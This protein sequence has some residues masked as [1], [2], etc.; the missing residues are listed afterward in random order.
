[1]M[2]TTSCKTRSLISK[3]RQQAPIVHCFTNMVTVNQVANALL[4]IGAK[5][6]MSVDAEEFSHIAQ[7]SQAFYLNIG[8]LKREEV[9]TMLAGLEAHHALGHPIVLDPVGAG[10]SSLRTEVA[11]DLLAS[12]KIT[13]LRGN[14]SEIQFLLG[15][16]GT[17]AGVDVSPAE[18]YDHSWERVVALAGEAAQKWQIL[19][20]ISG[21]VD[22]I[23][24]GQNA[25]TIANGHEM[26]K[27]I[28][29]TGCQLTGVIGA[30][31][32]VQRD[33][34]SLVTAVS[35]YDVAGEIGHSQLGR[36]E[37]P[38]SLQVRLLDALYH[39]TDALLLEH[40]HCELWER[41]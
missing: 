34:D 29:G 4:A 40:S 2:N 31:L 36:Y 5:P 6:I 1:M 17:S 16:G 26:M 18:D 23:H 20:A 25:Y 14:A 11:L 12:G 33:I 37:G 7:I 13:A 8:T 30:F 10:A 35:A 28:T 39:M 24:D 22:I 19:V 38:A 9:A 32:A 27:Y 41:M 3:L 21:P 15:Q